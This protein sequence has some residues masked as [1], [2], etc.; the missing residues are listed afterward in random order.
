MNIG[1][2]RIFCDLVELQNFSRTAERH[3]ISQSA[4]SQQLAQLEMVFKCQLI[5]R[6]KRPPGPTTAGELLYQA[7][8]DILDR[9]DK[10]QSELNA[11]TRSDTQINIAAIFSIGMHTL[12]PYVRKFVNE[13]PNIHLKVDYFSADR[14]YEQVLLGEVD[15]GLVAVPR[16]DNTIDVYPFEPEPLVFVCSPEH[17]LSSNSGLDIY[18]MRG[19][20]LI[21]FKKGVPTREYID[22]ILSRFHISINPLMEFDNIETMKRVV[23]I[24]AGVSIMP[25]T[26]IQTEVQ[27]GTLKA[28]PFSNAN[29][30]FVRPTGILVRRDRAMNKHKK[31][32]LDL[33]CEKT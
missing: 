17:P 25:K 1:T 20:E 12:Q 33:L 10:L 19:Q 16:Q 15:F 7:G 8:K 29:I 21:A 30:E 2:I 24:N 32:L 23:E 9:Y 26:A 4:V 13:Y 28:I 6:K 14:I 18:I 31:A 5:N 22:D 3:I 11:L 27:N